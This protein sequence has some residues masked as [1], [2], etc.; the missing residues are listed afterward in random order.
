[1]SCTYPK[2]NIC[3]II[4]CSGEKGYF[5]QDFPPIFAIIPWQQLSC[6]NM[7][8]AHLHPKSSVPNFIW[9]SMF[10]RGKTFCPN[11]WIFMAH[12]LSTMP[13]RCLKD[14]PRQTS[15][16]YFMTINWGSIKIFADVAI[17][18]RYHGNTLSTTVHMSCTSTPQG[19]HLCQISVRICEKLRK[20]SVPDFPRNVTMATHF[21]SRQ[22]IDLQML[23]I[24]P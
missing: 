10:R 21:L 2:A 1:M 18:C 7:C 23:H 17:I 8:L 20:C 6:H 12:T 15:L 4:S 9:G 13:W 11:F 14:T 3:A 5:A 16:P 24:K 19:K 22:K